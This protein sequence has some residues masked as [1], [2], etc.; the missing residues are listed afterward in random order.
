MTSD[1][2]TK[3]PEC[4][5]FK[6]KLQAGDHAQVSRWNIDRLLDQLSALA[7]EI[8]KLR[9]ASAAMRPL[10][11]C[12]GYPGHCGPTCPHKSPCEI[13]AVLEGH[14]PGQ[15][16]LNKLSRLERAN[17]LLV[18]ACEKAEHI[19]SLPKASYGAVLE[20]WAV[21]LLTE[22][23]AALAAAKEAGR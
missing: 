22:L 11:R 6:S 20:P 18:A 14:S 16:L 3:C 1:A 19:V 10:I 23:R 15:P 17:G 21:K 4:D 5:V 12:A 7:G 9:A 2:E 8:E 13:K